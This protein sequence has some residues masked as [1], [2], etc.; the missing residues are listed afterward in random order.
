MGWG[1]GLG[2]G[3]VVRVGG[4]EMSAAVWVAVG[5]GAGGIGWWDCGCWTVLYGIRERGEE[6]WLCGGGWRW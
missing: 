1:L 6:S 4:V 5:S 3:V 2:L